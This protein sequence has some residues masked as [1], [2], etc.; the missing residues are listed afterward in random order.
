MRVRGSAR[1][2]S[3]L[4]WLAAFGVFGLLYG[5][6]PVLLVDL[7]GALALSPGPLGAALSAGFVASL[8]A[9]AIAGRA[10][11]RWGRRAV[12]VGAGSAMALTWVGFAL[13]PSF[14]ALVGLL[15]CFYPASGVYD[16]GINAAAMA[17]EQRTGRRLL[18]L[19]HGAFSGGGA[20]GA[21]AAGALLAAGAPFRALYVLVAA[22]LLAVLVPVWRSER[23]V[24]ARE[25]ERVGAGGRDRGGLFRRRALLL[26]AGVAGFGFLFEGAME[27]WSVVYLRR[28]LDLP[29]L[30]GASGVAV[31]HTAMLTGRLATAATVA[32][33]GRRR[34]LRGAGTLAAAGMALAMATER[35]PLILLGFLAVGLS[36]SAVAPVTFSVA[37]DLAP[38]RSGEASSVI[39]TLGYG[40]FLV[41]PTLIG[42]LAE[43]F[44]L[45][46]AL[47]SLIPAGLLIAALAGRVGVVEPGV[48]ADRS[49]ASTR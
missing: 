19:F 34:T 3:I 16:V 46:A 14:A 24:V 48:G 47:A 7:S 1:F 6:W 31:F 18:P 38:D 40:G 22:L 5:F 4:P 39:T 49:A 21:L 10:T 15:A 41:G 26:V 2:A 43:A 42:G 35:A 17:A 11:D 30:L 28:S 8:P 13:V 45:R 20:V 25:R 9:M 33:F 12:T 36:L 29:V 44:G 32:R 27:T 23:G 37:G